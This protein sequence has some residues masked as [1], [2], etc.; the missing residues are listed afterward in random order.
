[1]KLKNKMID[2]LKAPKIE[3]WMSPDE[4]EFRKK[5]IE[6][7]HQA[8]EMGIV[9]FEIK[10]FGIFPTGETS[11]VFL[12]NKTFVVKMLRYSGPLE[13]EAAFFQIWR[14]NDIKTPAVFKV[15]TSNTEL[16]V[17]VSVLEYINADLLEKT[18]TPKER[19]KSG[20]SREMGIIMAKM[21]QAKGEK[22]G[23]PTFNNYRIGEFQNIKAKLDS[24]HGIKKRINFLIDNRI[25][26]NDF[27]EML[28]MSA[29]ILDKELEDGIQPTLNHND[30][31]PNNILNTKPL[32]IIDPT[33]E[34]NHPAIDLALPLLKSEIEDD[35]Y[36]FLERDEILNGYRSLQIISDSGLSAGFVLTGLELIYYWHR[37]D[38]V[39][40]VEKALKIL[41]KHVKNIQK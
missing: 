25:I 3:N 36:G 14:D 27:F 22:I 21:H 41:E 38:K 16:P 23:N 17:C 6:Y 30:F 5:A 4:I 31:R 8:S 37:S 9:P 13:S 15:H 29:N 24:D 39:K 2:F 40:K 20:V 7:L 19:I 33:P 12:V 11:V 35:K 32:T 34:I 10:E 26:N 28:S 18:T 1:M